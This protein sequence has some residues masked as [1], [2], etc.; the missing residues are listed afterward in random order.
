MM[1][2]A[3]TRVVETRVEL[4]VGGQILIETE[5]ELIQYLCLETFIRGVAIRLYAPR[6]VLNKRYIKVQVK[7][8]TIILQRV[9]VVLHTKTAGKI[10]TV[11]L[12][13]VV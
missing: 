9:A 13:I 6:K 5:V 1:I 10:Q 7:T 4:E 3:S 11:N 8:R 12:T 2:V